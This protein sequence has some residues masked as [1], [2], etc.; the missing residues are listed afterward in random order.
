M[1]QVLAD[2]VRA[3]ILLRSD[4]MDTIWEIDLSGMSLPVARACCRFILN[5]SKTMIG[6]G[7][8]CEDLIFITGTGKFH[9]KGSDEMQTKKGLGATTLRE[10]ISE[11]LKRDF[12]PP[13]ASTMSGGVVQIKKEVIEQWIKSQES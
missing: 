3:Q 13:L 12:D 1:D 5:R 8:A 11:I 2:A 6:D 10:Y 4:S 9:Q 7:T